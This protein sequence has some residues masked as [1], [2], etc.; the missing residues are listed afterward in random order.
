MSYVAIGLIIGLVIYYGN[1]EE[2][3]RAGMIMLP[4]GIAVVLAALSS[5]ARP[6]RCSPWLGTGRNSHRRSTRAVVPKRKGI[7]RMLRQV[8][9]PSNQLEAARINANSRVQ[10]ANVEASAMSAFLSTDN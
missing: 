6:S 8:R 2:E 1:E 3:R 5:L 9:V 7:H 4:V 10:A